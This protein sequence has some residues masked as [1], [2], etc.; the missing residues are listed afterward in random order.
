M[1]T[2]N[3]RISESCAFAISALALFDDATSHSMFDWPDA[4]H[5]SPTSTS[6][7]SRR[8]APAWTLSVNGPPA[9]FGDRV[10]F[11]AP[12]G[13]TVARP[14]LPASRTVTASLGFAHPQTT[15]GLSR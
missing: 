7:K 4:S 9:G 11:H 12:S 14:L 2:L 13:E 6:R 3:W 10:T 1:G 8:S 15:M 5:T